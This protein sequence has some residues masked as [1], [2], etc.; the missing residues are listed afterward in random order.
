VNGRIEDRE[1]Y[2][3]ALRAVQFVGPAGP[4]RFD[5]KQNA[6]INLYLFETREVAGELRNVVVD[7][8]G[9]G[10]TQR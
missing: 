7:T 2:L 1:G 4:F 10:V 5:G 8:I 6:V 9:R 3:R